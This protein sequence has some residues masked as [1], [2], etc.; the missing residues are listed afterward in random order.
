MEGSTNECKAKVFL[1]SMKTLVNFLEQIHAEE[2]LIKV[3]W[4]V[5]IDKIK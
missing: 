1:E 4:K 3:N 2:Q 5:V